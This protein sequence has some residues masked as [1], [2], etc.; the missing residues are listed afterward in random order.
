MPSEI[1]Y[2]HQEQT[3]INGTI[4][5]MA[6]PGSETGFY[7]IPVAN[8]PWQ[9]PW[10]ELKDH[11]RKVCPVEHVEINEDS[12]SGHVLLKGR[13]N[14]DAAFRLLNGGIFHDRAL[15]ADGRNADSWVLVKQHVDGNSPSLP[16]L[17]STTTYKAPPLRQSPSLMTQASQ[18]HGEWPVAS[19]AGLVPNGMA[20]YQSPAASY[21]TGGCGVEFSRSLTNPMMAYSAGPGYA[22]QYAPSAYAGTDY[23][24][25]NCDAVSGG[26]KRH[27]ADTAPSRKRKIIIRQLPSWVGDAQIR[28]LIHH[29]AGSAAEKLQR[30]EVNRGFALATFESEEAAVRAIK[31]LNNYKFE[32]RTLEAK[33]AKE[34]TSDHHHS[35]SSHAH[36]SKVSHQRP[37]RQERPEGKDRKGKERESSHKSASS[38]DKK[39]KS[40]SSKQDVVI[41]N[42]SS[43]SSSLRQK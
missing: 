10:Q 5:C 9:T 16:R 21:G 35:H 20:G 26:E 38:V 6:P 28:E 39:S 43:P 17:P 7:Y 40:S 36:G 14:F 1:L 42:G 30:L 32:G 34:G 13:A 2:Q 11:V 22:Q 24:F 33:H 15:I 27:S 12:T 8:L 19:S 4:S 31:K 25:Y 18:A 29:R 41:V 23:S 3:P 37:P